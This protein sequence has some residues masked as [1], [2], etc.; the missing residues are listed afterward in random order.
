MSLRLSSGAGGGGAV[1]ALAEP[2][3]FH[4]SK[5]QGKSAFLVFSSHP[6]IFAR[7]ILQLYRTTSVEVVQS[8]A[9]TLREMQSPRGE[10][11]DETFAT[12]A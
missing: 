2:F 12:K 6:S 5:H 4:L 9:A 3:L 8:A 11:D 1:A 10:V 7:R